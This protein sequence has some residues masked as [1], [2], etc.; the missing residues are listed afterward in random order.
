MK[1]ISKLIITL[2]IILLIICVSTVSVF[3]FLYLPYT[4]IETE[5]GKIDVGFNTNKSVV[6]KIQESIKDYRFK[7]KLFDGTVLEVPADDF[8]LEVDDSIILKELENIDKKFSLKPVKYTISLKDKISYDTTKIETLIQ[9]K[10]GEEVIESQD[11]Y[12]N[13]NEE[14]ITIIFNIKLSY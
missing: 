3:A 14:R 2:V 5:F 12:I 13:Y 7:V 8:I 1:S 9:E 4:D 6:S 11:A 10:S